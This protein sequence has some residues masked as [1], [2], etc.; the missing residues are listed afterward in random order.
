MIINLKGALTLWLGVGQASLIQG[1]ALVAGALAILI[2]WARVEW[3]PWQPDFDLWFSSTLILGTVLS[4]HLYI[5][6][7]LVYLLP[8]V[9]LLNFMRRTG[10]SIRALMLFLMSWPLLF[11]LDAFFF[12]GRL[13]IRT[14]VL[15]VV[16]LLAWMAWIG[17]NARR[18]SGTSGSPA[19]G[20][21]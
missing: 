18:L 7:C 4:P 9:L 17:W 2:W 15:L 19:L 10:Q 5:H 11:L 21:E 6:D 1:I 14:P 20:A 16:V 12:Q 13:G 8:V 3:E